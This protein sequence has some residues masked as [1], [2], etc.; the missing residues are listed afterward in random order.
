[1]RTGVISE[2]LNTIFN[3]ADKLKSLKEKK[4]QLENELKGCST[5]IEQVSRAMAD[6]MISDEIQNINRSG[7]CFYIVNKLY[8]SL[9]GEVEPEAYQVFKSHGYG[10]LIREY[11]FPQKVQVLCKQFYEDKDKLPEWLEPYVNVHKDKEINIEMRKWKDTAG[12]NTSSE[13]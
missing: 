9:K 1:M 3:K 5:E 8:A 10:D 13:F 2:K 6:E 4:G 11:I 12:Q 7:Y